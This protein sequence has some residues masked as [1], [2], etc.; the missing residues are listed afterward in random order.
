MNAM[1]DGTRRGLE[2]NAIQFPRRNGPRSGGGSADSLR[3]N[4]NVMGGW[5][6][7]LPRCFV[8]LGHI[9]PL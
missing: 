9:L 4:S 3:G 8:P 7:A 1:I 6:L 2:R 5:A